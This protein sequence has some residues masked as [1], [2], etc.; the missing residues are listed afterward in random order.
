MSDDAI[1]GQPMSDYVTVYS[2]WD[3]GPYGGWSP[4]TPDYKP[5]SDAWVG[6]VPCWLYDQYQEA[7][8]AR[9]AAESAMEDFIELACLK[10]CGHSDGWVAYPPYD[11]HGDRPHVALICLGCADLPAGHPPWSTVAKVTILEW[12]RRL[13][14]AD[15]NGGPTP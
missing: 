4:L 9:H 11:P 3:S 15:D 14:A 5:Y 8:A 12:L 6:A 7:S 13:A 10:D 2:W 1:S